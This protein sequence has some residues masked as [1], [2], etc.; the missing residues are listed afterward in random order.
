MTTRGHFAPVVVLELGLRS[1]L[2]GQ[3]LT[4]LAY[5]DPAGKGYVGRRWGREAG[6][7]RGWGKRLGYKKSNAG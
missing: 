4:G 7:F 1:I 3:L 5:S 2:T 6:G